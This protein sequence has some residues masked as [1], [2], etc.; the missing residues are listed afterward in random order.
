VE[1]EY[2]RIRMAMHRERGENFSPPSPESVEWLNGLIK[3]VWG[4]INP[5]MFIP[6]IDMV[7]DVL[8]A[9]L[10]GFIDAVRIADVGQGTNPLRIVSMR[11]LPDRP[12]DPKYPREEWVGLDKDAESKAKAKEVEKGKSDDPAKDLSEQVDEDQ[13]GDYLN[14]EISVSYQALPGQSKRLRFHNLHLML[15]FFV[16][17][18]DWFRLPIPIY[19]IVE[20]FVATVRLRVQFIQ[21]PPFVRNVTI[22]LMGVPKVEVSVELFTTKLPNVLDLP[23]IKNFVEMGIAAAVSSNVRPWF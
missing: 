22:T 11:A 18:A 3:L 13:T 23:F 14:Y 15:E 17:L 2:E 5:D 4:L 19:A 21:S 6:V 10:P 16:G 9:S 20:G 12:G 1:K 8:Q 7:E